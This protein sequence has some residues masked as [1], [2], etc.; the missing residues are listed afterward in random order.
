MPLLRKRSTVSIAHFAVF[1]CVSRH[2]CRPATFNAKCRLRAFR[3]SEFYFISRANKKIDRRYLAP[4]TRRERPRVISNAI[5]FVPT[6][7]SPTRTFELVF[8]KLLFSIVG[9]FVRVRVMKGDTTR[10]SRE[11]HSDRHTAVIATSSLSGCD[12]LSRA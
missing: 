12:S 10:R 6:R 3:N 5:S 4:I 9:T 7:K 2:S 8:I 1:K 11:R